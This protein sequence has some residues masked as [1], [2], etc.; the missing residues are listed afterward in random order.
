M[1]DADGR[2]WLQNIS[3]TSLSRMVVETIKEAM[4]NG[5]LKPGDFLPSESELIVR[6]GVGKSSVREAIKMLEALG[7]VEIIKGQGS[8]IRTEV[9]SDCM[10]PFIFQLILD[11]AGNAGS[12]LEFRVM[13][14]TSST[15]LAMKK[16][17]PEDIALLHD[18]YDRMRRDFAAGLHEPDNDIA[19][20]QA[21]Y[22]ATHNPFIAHLGGMVIRL[23]RPSLAIANKE[24]PRRVLSDHRKILKAMEGKD[25]SAVKKVIADSLSSWHHLTLEK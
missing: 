16:A 9:D 19:F 20:H 7:V 5:E 21:V 13:F 4:I 15:L 1:P 3:K 17:T 2:K 8:R 22:D 25:G 10:D 24:Y 6:L 12:M 11:C 23:F 18:L 14:E